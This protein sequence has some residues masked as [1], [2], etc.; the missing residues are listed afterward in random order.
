MNRQD[1]IAEIKDKLPCTDYLKR[2]KSGNY[3]CP[4]CGSGTGTH[5][6]GAVKV[7][8][9]NTFYCHACSR[10]GD[11]LDLLQI[12][13]N[14]D[15]N[16]AIDAGAAALGLT[17]DRKN[18]DLR[19]VKPAKDKL[20]AERRKDATG[21]I[22]G[23]SKDTPAADYTAYYEHCRKRLTDPAAISYLSAR[24]IS[25]D[26]AA[27]L[28]VGYDPA[29]DPAGAPG[30][31]D[32]E[33]KAHPV[34]RLII[35]TGPAHYVGRR[36]D[37][38]KDFD[39][40]NC[41]GGTPGIFNA[42][43]LDRDGLVFVTE[44][45]FDAMSFAECGAAAIA[46]NST[47]NAEKVA[48]LL[49]QAGRRPSIVVVFDND[50]DPATHTRTQRA[51]EALKTALQAQ[52]IPCM[53]FD[54]GRY[55][56]DGEKDVNDILKRDKA[57]VIRMIE[58]AKQAMKQERSKDELT[59][60]IEGVQ[61]EKYMPVKTGLPFFDELLGGGMIK[62]TL[63]LLL[64]SP[65]C[66]KTTL[67]QQI[68]EA[69]AARKQPVI[70][71]N[72]EMSR[73]QM[74]A[75]AISSRLAAGNGPY[76]TATQILQGY[77]WTLDQKAAILQEIDKYRAAVFPYLRYNPDGVSSDLDNLREYLQKTGTE[78]K[79]A[80]RQAP[81]IV[82]DY[83]HLVSSSRGLD[84]AEL[85]KQ[86]LKALKDY[87]T[88]YD[89]FVLAIVATRRST[90]GKV[91]L[92]SGRDTSNIEYTADTQISLNFFDIDNGT[93]DADDPEAVG[94]LQAE[95]WRRMILRVLKS[96]FGQPGKTEKVYYDAAHNYFLTV[97]G[98]TPKGA[99][100]FVDV[101]NTGAKR[102]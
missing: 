44:G 78:A 40:V 24:G 89:T 35:P 85:I 13:Y 58:D 88:E 75:K 26:T 73:E 48:D 16:A 69:A 95:P 97:A 71:L 49:Q 53:V 62:Q 74:I 14:M 12:T 56:R 19:G 99:K 79:T 25:A 100:P 23:R 47:S 70:Y 27:A 41:K 45:A 98:F 43:A 8:D 51:A 57:E 42:A 4:Y 46:T 102:R 84:N 93:V 86:T 31:A 34:P 36:I 6:T 92:S 32:K 5:K 101:T 38:V 39:K 18:A 15:L 83:L 76:M 3:C 81:A 63:L 87:A 50:P 37:G 90:D 59:A 17:T 1:I 80:G 96:R 28:G 29:A 21:G 55:T 77:N 9:T 61:S 65:G 67:C 33:Y 2:S 82:L 64:A 68:A 11:V 94:K 60:F 10:G 54:I 91:T 52:K 66:G 22:L 72:Y 20:P 7:Y 30:A